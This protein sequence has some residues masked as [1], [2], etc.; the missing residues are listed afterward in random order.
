M[1][2]TIMYPSP[3]YVLVSPVEVEDLSILNGN[4]LEYKD[5]DVIA[6]VGYIESIGA[7]AYKCIPNNSRLLIFNSKLGTHIYEDNQH[8]Y[9]IHK[10]AILASIAEATIYVHAKDIEGFETLED[11]TYTVKVDNSNYGIRLSYLVSQ[12]GKPVENVELKE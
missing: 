12:Y 7:D 10:S 2:K 4:P 6:K 1:N 9:I 11:K 5:K 8:F 3:N